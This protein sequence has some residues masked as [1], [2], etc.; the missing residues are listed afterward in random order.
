LFDVLSDDADGRDDS[1]GLEL[2]NWKLYPRKR[3]TDKN[4]KSIK[5]KP[6]AYLNTG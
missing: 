3:Q 5:E 2:Q 6:L 4:L 1:L